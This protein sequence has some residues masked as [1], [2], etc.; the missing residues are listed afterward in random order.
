MGNGRGLCTKLHKQQVP[1]NGRL[2]NH[3]PGEREAQ[4]NKGR[5]SFSFHTLNE[6]EEKVKKD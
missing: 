4:S 6:L 5:F 1:Q 2:A 3:K